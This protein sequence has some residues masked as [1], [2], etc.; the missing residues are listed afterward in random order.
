MVEV[1]SHEDKGFKTVMQFGAW[2]VAIM[3][4]APHQCREAITQLSRHIETDEAFVLL[5][6]QAA[7]CW[8]NEKTP[9]D[10]HIMPL[11][12]GRIYNVRRGAWHAVITQPGAKL[13][14]IENSDTG[15]HNSE[16]YPISFL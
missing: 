15:A 6:G 3:N 14:V 1:F 12:T 8:A 7:I 4:H 13:A 5:C 11:E 16:K 2:R 9:E 10:V